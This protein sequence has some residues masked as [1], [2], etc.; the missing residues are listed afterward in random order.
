MPTIVHFEIPADDVERSKK[1][2]SDLFGW[3]IEKWPGSTVD[4]KEY[5]MITTTDEKGNK[6]L[7]GGMMK[8]QMSQHQNTNFIDVESVDEY[9][10]KVQQLGGKVVVPKMSVPGMGY[11]AY[12]LDTENNSFGIW[13]TNESAK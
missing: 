7:G 8:R 12:C 13:E 3:K 2:Y 10:S 1:F 5:W 4:D 6:A 9:S 11:L